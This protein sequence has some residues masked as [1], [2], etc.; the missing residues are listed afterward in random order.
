MKYFT[1]VEGDES[2]ESTSRMVRLDNMRFSSGVA[3]QAVVQGNFGN[4]SFSVEYSFDDPNDLINPVPVDEMSWFTD[5]SPFVTTNESGSG[6]MPVAPLYVRINMVG[7]QGGVALTMTQYR[8]S[9]PTAGAPPGPKAPINI[10]PPLVAGTGAVGDTLTVTQ[11]IWA[12]SPTSI[13]DQWQRNGTNISGATGLTY[14]L[15]LADGG[16]N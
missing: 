3:L 6:F 2:G 8:R 16:T 1:E 7:S 13:V 4:S 10:T 15:Q 5:F 11:G 9:Y 14:E 12:N